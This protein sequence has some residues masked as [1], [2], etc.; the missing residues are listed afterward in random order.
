MLKKVSNTAIFFNII[1][2]T[3]W[4]F[5]LKKSLVLSSLSLASMDKVSSKISN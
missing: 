4:D 5:C 3:A 1:E 2:K